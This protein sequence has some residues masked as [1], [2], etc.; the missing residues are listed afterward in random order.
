MLAEIK[1]S[2][3][4]FNRKL[5]ST[6]FVILSVVEGSV[7]YIKLVLG[8]T[9]SFRINEFFNQLTQFAQWGIKT[10]EA[11]LYKWLNASCLFRK[12]EGIIPIVVIAS[13]AKQSLTE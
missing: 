8:Q 5:P 4:G 10:M 9:C 13:G 12:V 7:L 1:N 11:I 6:N 3:S 2:L